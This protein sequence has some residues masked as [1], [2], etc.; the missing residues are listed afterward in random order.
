M[1]VVV[2]RGAGSWVEHLIPFMPSARQL[3]CLRKHAFNSLDVCVC[4]VW[5]A[6]ALV[7]TERQTS[8]NTHHDQGGLC[9]PA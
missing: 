5:Q 3:A 8:A 7:H 6:Y 1:V 2:M 4:G 9:H